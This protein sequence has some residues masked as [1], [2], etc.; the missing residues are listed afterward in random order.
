ME[1]KVIRAYRNDLSTLGVLLVNGRF[2]CYTLEDAVRDHKIHGQTAIPEGH[3]RLT[4]RTAGGM[5]A[6]YASK[7]PTIHKGML[8]LRD[9]PGFRWVY[10]HIGNF[11]RDTEG[12]IL[13]GDDPLNPDAVS[14]AYRVM[15]STDA[16]LSLYNLVSTAIE[17][18]EE[19]SVDVINSFAPPGAQPKEEKR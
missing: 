11:I 9:V 4:L 18:S 8:R 15:R 1:L 7:F 2:R 3:Y 12:C 10:L 6:R 19:C 16:Y 17:R 5:N 14:P 13:V